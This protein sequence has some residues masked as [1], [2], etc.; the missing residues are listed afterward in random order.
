MLS[1]VNRIAVNVPPR[2]H[3]FEMADYKIRELGD[4]ALNRQLPKPSFYS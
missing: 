4:W 3:A 1:T 2:Q